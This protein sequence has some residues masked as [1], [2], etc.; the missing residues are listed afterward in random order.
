M[1]NTKKSLLIIMALAFSMVLLV[2][3]GKPSPTK[4]AG[5]FLKSYSEPNLSKMNK[6]L[7]ED[8]KSDEEEEDSFNEEVNK[9]NEEESKEALMYL[10]RY[11]S[12]F[13]YEIIEENIDEENNTASVKVSYVFADGREVFGETLKEMMGQVFGMAFTGSEPSQEEVNQILVDT[14]LRKL[15]NAEIVEEGLVGNIELEKVDGNWLISELDENSMTVLTFGGYE[16]LE[17]MESY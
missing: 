3:C 16:L 9:L 6:Y 15:E 7:I 14:V 8:L 11:L 1:K 5:G 10:N 2:G 12:K 17:L 13:T 4:V